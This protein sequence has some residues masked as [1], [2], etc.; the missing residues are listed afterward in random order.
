MA[1]RGVI[2]LGEGDSAAIE[3]AARAASDAIPTWLRHNNRLGSIRPCGHRETTACTQD[4]CTVT[5]PF[6]AL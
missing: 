2:W 6:R 3:A 1:S 4:R 5:Q